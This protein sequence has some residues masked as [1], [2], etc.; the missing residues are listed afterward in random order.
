MKKEATSRVVS[1]IQDLLD[2]GLSVEKISKRKNVV[3]EE[4]IHIKE[5]YDEVKSWFAKDNP[6]K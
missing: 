1:S 3:L 6:R 4:V 2:E 5:I